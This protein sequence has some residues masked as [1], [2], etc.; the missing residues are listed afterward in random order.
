[1]WCVER[2]ED[3]LPDSVLF[4]YVGHGDQI[5]VT[6]L[7]TSTFP[8]RAILLAY[9]PLSICLFLVE[10]QGCSQNSTFMAPSIPLVYVCL[11]ISSVVMNVVH[12]SE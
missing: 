6:S 5:W 1:M 7:A 3:D 10:Q 2:S 9:M 12:T 4:Y 8:L 11:F